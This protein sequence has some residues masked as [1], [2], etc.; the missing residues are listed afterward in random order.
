[1]LAKRTFI[2]KPHLKI[3]DAFIFSLALIEHQ[4]KDDKYS[5]V[6]YFVLLFKRH[7]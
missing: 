1:M 3:G 4:Q 2:E 5:E 7:T 6:I